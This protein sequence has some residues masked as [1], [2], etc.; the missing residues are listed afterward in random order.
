MKSEE[1]RSSFLDYFSQLG[2]RIVPSSSLLPESPNL[3][4]TNAGMNQFVPFFLG[5]RKSPQG[6]LAD[7]QKCLRAGGKHNDLTDVGHDTYHHTFFEMLGNWSFGDYFKADAIEWAWTFLT[8]IWLLPKHRLYATVY[9]PGENEPSHFD[10]EA[11]S[12]WEKIFLREKMDPRR[13]IRFGNARDNFW[14]MGETGPCGPCSEIHMDLTESGQNGGTLVNGDSPRCMELWN[15]VF[16]QYNALGDGRFDPLP[17]Q[18]VD[19]GMGLERI[20]GIFATSNNLTDFSRPPSNYDSDLFLPIIREM[21]VLGTRGFRYGGTVAKAADDRTEQNEIDCAFRVVA[22]HLRALVFAVGDGI[23]PDRD[24]R[25]YVIRRILRRAVMFGNRLL[26]PSNFL[27]R[28]ADT[29]IGH[30]GKFY[31]EL[32]HQRSTIMDILGQEQATFQRT[33][34]RGCNLLE[35]ALA[36][37]PSRLPGSIAFELYDTYG[38]PLDLTELMAA[39]RGCQVER[40]DFDA[41][42]DRQQSLA[43]NAQKKAKII[44]HGESENLCQFIGHDGSLQCAATI[45]SVLPRKPRG[46]YLLTDLTPFYGERGGQIGDS[47]WVE[48]HSVVHRIVDTQIAADGNILHAL[49]E[50]LGGD[51]CGQRCDLRV[52]GERRQEIACHHTATHLLQWAL[53][54]VLGDHVRQRGSLVTD[55]LLR[56][57]FAHFE[58][59]TP[60]QLRRVEELVNGQ[61]RRNIALNCYETNFREKPD[62]C[63]AHFG[64]RYGDR[65]RV[66]EIGTSA[67]LCGGT[68]LRTTGE[69]GFFKITTESA[70]A[71]ATRRIEAVAGKAAC[72]FILDLCDRQEKTAQLLH[73]RLIEIETAAQKLIEERVGLERKVDRLSR[74]TLAAQRRTLL[75]NRETITGLD[76]IIASIGAEN[77]SVLKDFAREL[78]LQL[79]EGVV[80]LLTEIDGRANFLATCSPTAIGAGITAKGLIKMFAD[81]AGGKGGGKDDFASGGARKLD[82]PEKLLALFRRQIR[83]KVS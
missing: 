31:P 60:D 54:Q 43:R 50:E 37:N 82:N 79:E 39:E 76:W 81:L 55:R 56:F 67:E 83:G 70:I 4:F 5:D 58:P 61:V 68:H 73:C 9:Q 17:S 29:F 26:L 41:L 63:L 53:R 46:S 78:A 77:F 18:F 30:M 38:F 19:T 12:V 40:G 10:E 48:I 23:R 75:D 44:L 49:D 36:A 13:H 1:L 62:H 45:R 80:F 51:L 74:G 27:S 6:R 72:Q 65:V 42:M 15:L 32:D 64:E 2:H 25:N 20:A 71:A 28:L 57:D 14:M 52:D 22:D 24:G 33:L 16:I 3:L 21:E 35:K 59:P 7:A 66:V 8:K 69:I 34:H 11:F 47:G